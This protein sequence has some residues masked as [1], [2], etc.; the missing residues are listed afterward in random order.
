[1]CLSGTKPWLASIFPSEFHRETGALEQLPLLEHAEE[2]RVPRLWKTRD[3]L[4]LK[5]TV[6][7]IIICHH[8]VL[9]FVLS[10][11]VKD[12]QPC[13]IKSWSSSIFWK[14]NMLIF[15]II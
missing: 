4:A 15:Y 14:E 7:Q 8:L 12:S 5:K 11:K 3:G 10:L 6:F 13:P 1:M 9:C 2:L